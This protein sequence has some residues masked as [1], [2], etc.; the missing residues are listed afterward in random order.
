[1]LVNYLIEEFQGYDGDGEFPTFRDTGGRISQGKGSIP[2][3]REQYAQMPP[4]HNQGL[5]VVCT[6]DN[7]ATIDD[8]YDFFITFT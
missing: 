5:A 1:M 3:T 4:S 2:M 8:P 7:F 6:L